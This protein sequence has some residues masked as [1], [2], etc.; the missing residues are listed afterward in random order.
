MMLQKNESTRWAKATVQIQTF[1]AMGSYELNL[2]SV[3]PEY[4]FE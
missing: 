2:K 4:I 1:V 3:T